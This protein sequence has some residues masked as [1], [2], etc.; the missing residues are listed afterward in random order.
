MFDWPIIII[1]SFTVD[2]VTLIMVYSLKSVDT[3]TECVSYHDTNKSNNY[4]ND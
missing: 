4:R 1:N 2:M 3:V